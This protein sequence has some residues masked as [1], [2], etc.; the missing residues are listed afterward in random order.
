MKGLPFF[1]A[2][3]FFIPGIAYG[4][5]SGSFKSSNDVVDA[6]GNAM[7]DMG[8]FV[9]LCFVIAQFL[10]YFDWSNIAVILA[11]KG[12]ILLEN[13]GLPIIV[14][15]VLFVILCGCLNMFIGSA[16][17][18][19]GL[20]ASVFVPMFMILGYHPAL[21]QM[22]YRIGDAVTNP[23]T[24]AFAYF[25]M[26]LALCKKYDNSVGFGTLMANMLPYSIAF[27][28]VFIIQLII[29]FV[30]QIPFGFGAG[31]TL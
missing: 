5:K 12:A 7:V 19:W 18:K 16:S 15:L 24:P 10:K 2:L 27:F 1:I 13:S 17:A 22:C 31:V 9:A 14:I 11:I 30:F 8:P 29:W 20:M 3:L 23:I 25:A 4:F 21:I 28:V 6:L 26:L